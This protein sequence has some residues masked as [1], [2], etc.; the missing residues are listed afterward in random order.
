MPYTGTP[1]S[2]FDPIVYGT[3]LVLRPCSHADHTISS[4][5]DLPLLL[6]ELFQNKLQDVNLRNFTRG[7]TNLDRLRDGLV[8]AQVTM[9]MLVGCTET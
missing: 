9:G 8:G 1:A 2:P 5:N 6:R 7:Q 3:A 4:H